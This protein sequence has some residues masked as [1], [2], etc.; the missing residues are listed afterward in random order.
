MP[1]IFGILNTNLQ[2]PDPEMISRMKSAA[3]YIKPRKIEAFE[4]H[5][6]FM[7]AAVVEENP[8]VERKN[9]MTVDGP[10]VVL[11]D[12]SLYKREELIER[13]GRRREGE[14]DR[15]GEKDTERQRDGE[16]ERRG[17]NKSG[18]ENENS[19]FAKAPADKGDTALILEAWL[20]W[21]RECV[22][23][24]YGDF[25][26]VIFN[27]ETGEIFC[28]RDPMGV[29]PFFYSFTGDV[30]AFGSELRYVL[31]SFNTKPDLLHEYLLDTLVTI[32]SS[33]ELSPFK[34]IFRLK[35]G[36]CLHK[37][38][39]DQKISQY[40]K[41]D[42]EKR[43]QLLNEED[44]IELFREKFVNAVNMRCDGVLELGCELSGGLDSSAVTG[45]AADFAAHHGTSMTAFSN[46]FP[47]DTGIDFKD[48]RE[49]IDGMT[50]FIAIP[51]IGVDQAGSA[52]PELLKFSNDIQGCFVQ[53]N[54]NV[55]NRGI[56][57]AAGKK[58]IQALLSGFGGDELV[59]ARIA[60][61]WS[62]LI[63]DRQW[64]VIIDEL[65]HNGITLKS[66]L[67][68]GLLA[69][70]YLKSMI[71]HPK[72]RTGIF[73]P[74]LL[75]RRFANLPLNSKF[76]LKNALRKRFGENFRKPWRNQI[77]WRQFDRIM[78]DHVPQRMEYCYTAAVQYGLEYRYP[79]WDIDLI[80]TCL[81][82][83]PWMKQH[84]SINRY[85][86]RQAIKDFVPEIIWKRDDKS[87]TTIPQMHYSLMN[88]KDLILDLIRSCSDSSYL[89]EIVDFSGF[90][91][92]YERL[93]KRDKA[94]MNYLMP[95]AFYNYL[96]ILL[97]FKEY[98]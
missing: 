96:M 30:F 64:D 6:G 10:W 92:W 74:K 84:H 18:N 60:M 58:N 44:Y 13:I 41:P 68:P 83:P 46:V 38:K 61:P 90:P 25:A 98:G 8:L 9:T 95:G 86:F 26:F 7:A 3:R 56:Y 65:Y 77:T 59:S 62:E 48:E 94:D 36:H 14:T 52:I 80:E 50:R 66:L 12:V 76:A 55:F 16:T 43:I 53:Q 69:I 15:P 93:V 28:G 79:L 47:S 11:A 54:Y 23:F 32:K 85:V 4:I 2:K 20:K 78:L 97:Y 88:E 42:P 37:T 22:K 27:R 89:N 71:Y 81:A 1:P 70:R 29:R 35:P 51:W 63:H 72:Y 17:K 39:E 82:F 31:A 49:F 40:W 45:I 21:G 5:G 19:T 33:K 87:G 57:E 24:L 73:T 75:D 91:Q 67:K 34:N